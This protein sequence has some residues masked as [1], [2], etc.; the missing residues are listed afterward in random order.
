MSQIPVHNLASGIEHGPYE[1]MPQEQL[2][3]YIELREISAIRLRVPLKQYIED[4]ES[5]WQYDQ[6]SEAVMRALDA[7]R[8][9]PEHAN[10]MIDKVLRPWFIG[11][12]NV[13]DPILEMPS[14]PQTPA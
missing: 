9:T 5:E 10:Y 4:T 7:E 3:H 1:A 2:N 8:I 14:E 13:E 12:R 11:M 6:H